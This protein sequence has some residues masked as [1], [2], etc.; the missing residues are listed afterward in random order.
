MKR[1]AHQERTDV[2]GGGSC[3]RVEVEETMMPL[4]H[5]DH[6]LVYSV[7]RVSGLEIVGIYIFFLCHGN[8]GLKL[9]VC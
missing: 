3:C 5:G 7:V 6:R 2:V 4:T 9:L 8:V 1:V